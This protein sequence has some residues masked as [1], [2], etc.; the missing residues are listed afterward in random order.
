MMVSVSA[1]QEE[2]AETAVNVQLTTTVTQMCNVSVSVNNKILSKSLLQ[3]YIL[4]LEIVMCFGE[5]VL[6]VS[7]SVEKKK[8]LQNYYSI[9]TFDY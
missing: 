6:N 5:Y 8:I 3:L 9:F 7:L 2:E 1:V 4:S